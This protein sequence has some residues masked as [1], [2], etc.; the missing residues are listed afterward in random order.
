[1]R[2]DGGRNVPQGLRD[3]DIIE[4]F[5]RSSGRGGQHVNKTSTC[6]QL[7]HVPTGISV[8][9]QSERSQSRNRAE[10]YR[11]LAEKV[12][13][14]AERERRRKEQEQERER[15]RKRPRPARLRERILES[16]RRTAEKKKMRMKGSEV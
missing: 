10:A 14:I 8:K 3:E 5:V 15:R 12:E 9:V 13:A 7:S 6:V 11:L 4:K 16:K 2:R 1:M